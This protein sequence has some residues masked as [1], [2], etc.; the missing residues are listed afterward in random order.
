MTYDLPGLIDHKSITEI[1]NEIDS[2]WNRIFVKETNCRFFMSFDWIVGLFKGEIDG[3]RAC[4]T[5]YHDLAHTMDTCLVLARMLH[6]AYLD[7][8]NLE[9]NLSSAALTAALFHDSGYIQTED[10]SIGTGAKY[11]SVHV[12]RSIDMFENYAKSAGWESDLAGMTSSMIKATDLAIDMSQIHFAG[13]SCKLMSRFL[14]GADLLAQMAD[15]AYLEKL[16]YLYYELKEGGVKEFNSEADLLAK[17]LDFYRFVDRRMK[18]IVETADHYLKLHFEHR[19]GVEENLYRIS[20]ERQRVYL[21]KVLELSSKAPQKY[22]RRE[23]IVEKVREKY[24]R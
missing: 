1:R 16:L 10:D 9:A 18:D 7:G 23:G 6:G 4:N 14:A 3:Y 20:I 21:E 17:T 2:I 24:C 13:E 12:D 15:R 22:L 8:V 19:W 5:D 11:T